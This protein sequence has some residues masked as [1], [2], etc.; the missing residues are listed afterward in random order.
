MECNKFK[1]LI[2]NRKIKKLSKLTLIVHI[3]RLL[4][5]EI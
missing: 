5:Q 4:T 3:N 2:E 1:K